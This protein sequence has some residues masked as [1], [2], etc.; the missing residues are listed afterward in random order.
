[1][2]AY[3]L[4]FYAVV[5]LSSSA[6]LDVQY[7][8]LLLKNIMALSYFMRAPM[9]QWCDGKTLIIQMRPIKG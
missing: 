5:P 1:M 3:K 8:Y 2:N 7:P 4:L 9:D 6:V